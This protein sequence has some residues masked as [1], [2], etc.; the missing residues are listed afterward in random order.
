MQTDF[1]H[2]N[3]PEDFEYS[4]D[5][6][7][8]P[9]EFFL[10]VFPKSKNVW[11]KLGYFSSTAFRSIAFGFAQFVANGGRLKLV[12][13]HFLYGNDRD[14][15]F[16]SSGSISE[17][18]YLDDLKWITEQLTSSDEHFFSC[19]R[20]L[21]AENRLEIVPV[22]L[23]PQSMAHFKRGVFEDSHGHLIHTA[24][25][26]N[27]TGSG[28]LLNAE[29]LTVRTSWGSDFERK[30]AENRIREIDSVINRSDKKYHYL[31][32]SEIEDQILKNAKDKSV[33]DLLRDEARLLDK[34][35]SSQV[36]KARDILR[37]HKAKLKISI[38]KTSREPSFPYPSGPYDY[39]IEARRHWL[40]NGE[41][42]I[43]AMATGTG[44]TITSLNCVLER[45]KEVGV[46]Q[47]VIFVPYKV[48]V[49][50]WMG[51]ARS[52]KFENIILLS[53]K[54]RQWRTE[55]SR[56]CTQLILKPNTSFVIISTYDSL[57]TKDAMEG[58]IKLGS[59]TILIA[60][61]AHNAGARNTRASLSELPFDRRI[62]LSATLTR[63]FDN[64]G[65]Q[66]IEQYF[67]DKSPYTFEY[68]ME[69]A[70]SKGVLCRYEYTPKVVRLT[71][72]EMTV[73]R[74]KSQKLVKL[75]DHKRGVFK[76]PEQA[77]FLLLE[78]ARII[79]KAEGKLQAFVDCC[80]RLFEESG[81]LKYT[82]IY[83]PEGV[84][85]ED[86]NILDSFME[87]FSSE[88]PNITIGHYT[89]ETKNR[90]MVL[91]SFEDGDIDVLFS[92]KC[93][94][95]GVDIP[96]AENAIFCSSTGNPRQFIQ[97]RGR[98]LRAHPEKDKAR[99]YDLVVAP[100]FETSVDV[101]ALD[102]KLMLSELV[103]VLDFARLSE[104]YY[105]AT[106]ILSETCD[107]FEISIH[108]LSAA[109]EIRDFT[110]D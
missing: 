99:I 77:R 25:S 64:D 17:P 55:L 60:D 105:A 1:R 28:L 45:Y 69:Q 19:L 44:K 73:Y 12:T 13:N 72:D 3:F 22:M 7:R 30:V 29:S 108:A 95:E 81:S 58:L 107:R 54:N 84:D 35:E 109:E 9:I 56:L 10:D 62:A 66:F 33:F 40:K 67:D 85:K 15:V 21:L 70:L 75:F 27:F 18:A 100:H 52:F 57:Q 32:K 42:G 53:S 51:E 46:Y 94:D 4:S 78:R 76:N 80:K 106:E 50:Q 65:N 74:E 93:L 98:V 79:H 103:R 89:Y 87:R 49:E 92:M 88:F 14:L 102:K 43:F 96:R 16:D 5:T 90:E 97:R 34:L 68:S 82:F 59:N 23:K 24:G 104:T 8:L 38:E 41:K 37:R 101:S 61:E 91:K 36:G 47:V 86:D 31:K 48:L 6:D 26:G 11:L 63:R 39:Q 2:I 110:D 20:C 83:V 71:R